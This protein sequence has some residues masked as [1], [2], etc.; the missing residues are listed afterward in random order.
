MGFRNSCAVW[1]KVARVLTTLWRRK[2]FK[3]VHLLDDLL[4]SVSGTFED[5]CKDDCNTATAVMVSKTNK[6]RGSEK[7]QSQHLMPTAAMASKR[8]KA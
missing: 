2:G 8:P 4:F 7:R 3:L 5:A 1:T 6:Q